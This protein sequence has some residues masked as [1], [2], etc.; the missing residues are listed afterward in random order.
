MYTFSIWHPS[1]IHN[2]FTFLI[3]ESCSGLL[4][5]QVA[6]S[7]SV[8]C[9][10]TSFQEHLDIAVAGNILPGVKAVCF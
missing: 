5:L 2:M 3:C 8:P 7:K 1:D 10:C 4:I 9:I 6:A